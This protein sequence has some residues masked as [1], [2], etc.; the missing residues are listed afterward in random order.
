MRT[1]PSGLTRGERVADRRQARTVA[2]GLS[3]HC[4]SLTPLPSVARAGARWNAGRPQF[5]LTES[6]AVTGLGVSR[7]QRS[8]R[9]RRSEGVEVAAPATHAAKSLKSCC[10]HPNKLK[11]PETNISL[12]MLPKHLLGLT[13]RKITFWIEHCI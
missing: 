8:G 9:L 4:G 5:G 11:N 6:P 10:M 1:R 7:R 12:A 2:V 13:A 3:R